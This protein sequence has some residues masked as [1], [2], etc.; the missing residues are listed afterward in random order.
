MSAVQTDSGHDMRWR[1]RNYSEIQLL[2]SFNIGII[3][4]FSLC[5]SYHS[6]HVNDSLF[7][8]VLPTKFGRATKQ[9][10]RKARNEIKQEETKVLVNFSKLVDS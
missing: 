3:G 1:G 9:N 5:K 4:E 6:V 2:V 7:C 10:I 8:D